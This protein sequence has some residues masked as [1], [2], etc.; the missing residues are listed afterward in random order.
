ML[1]PFVG[2]PF[3]AIL[4]DRDIGECS[5][6]DV[7]K[8]DWIASK[9]PGLDPSGCGAFEIGNISQARNEQYDGI[10]AFKRTSNSSKDELNVREIRE[11][12]GAGPYNLF[13]TLPAN[14]TEYVFQAL[15]PR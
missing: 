13:H 4:G 8:V 9:L 12:I 11:L 15:K 14:A 7:K 1:G 5:K 6:L 3:H 10:G 2:L